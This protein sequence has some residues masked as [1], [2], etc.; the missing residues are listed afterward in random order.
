MKP[1]KEKPYIVKK[2]NGIVKHNVH[3]SVNESVIPGI[4]NQ[5]SIHSEDVIKHKPIIE[6][7]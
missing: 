7:N 6:D 3:D 2:D 4:S 1:V 5:R